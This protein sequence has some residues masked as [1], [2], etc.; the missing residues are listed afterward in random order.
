MKHVSS[1]MRAIVRNFRGSV[2]VPEVNS[3][4]PVAGMPGTFTPPSLED[5][6]RQYIRTEVS[7]AADKDGDE[8]FEESDDFD[9][10]PDEEDE[11]PITHHEVVGMTDEEL[12]GVAHHYGVDTSLDRDA[13][14]RAPVSGSP[15]D[16]APDPAVPPTPPAPL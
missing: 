3:G 11:L 15:G 12:H 5:M 2:R 16:K 4:I 10:G 7:S 13:G 9:L 6:I 8:T 1:V 14:L